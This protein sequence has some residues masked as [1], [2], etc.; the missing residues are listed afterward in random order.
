MCGICG[1]IA[2]PTDLAPGEAGAMA[3]RLRHRGPGDR[4]GAP[5]ADPSE[6]DHLVAAIG[7]SEGGGERA[8]PVVQALQRIRRPFLVKHIPRHDP[9]LSIVEIRPRRRAR[10]QLI[11]RM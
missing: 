3:A 11:A 7:E 8:S 5:T 10:R 1:T 2:S 9:P 6:L 4:L